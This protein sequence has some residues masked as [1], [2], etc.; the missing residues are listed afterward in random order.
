MLK[1]TFLI[2]CWLCLM[3]SPVQAATLSVACAANFTS[4]MK[5]LASLYSKTHST[6]VNC[7]FGSTGMLYGQIIKGAPYDLFFA[8]DEKRPAM[9]HEQG[10]SDVPTRYAQG[11]VVVWSNREELSSMPNWKEVILSS[12]CRRV[13]IANPKTAPYG[14]KA[15]AAMAAEG[16]LKAVTPKLAFGKSVGTSFQYAYSGAANAAFVAKSQALSEKGA[17]GKYWPI[18]EAGTVNQAV[19]LL[20][21]GKKELATQF[22]DWLHT[23]TARAMIEGYGYE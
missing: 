6:K 22:L 11:K 20:A 4:A 13:G 3:A 7:T 1:K 14:L 19:C 18:P 5:D 17:A 9:L 23:P 8:A 12:A 16:I 10:L 15:E 2:F 21:N